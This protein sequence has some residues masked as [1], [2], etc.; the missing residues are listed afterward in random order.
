MHCSITFCSTDMGG[1]ASVNPGGIVRRQYRKLRLGTVALRVI[2]FLNA[3]APINL[4]EIK[5]VK[6]DEERQKI[7]K[8]VLDHQVPFPV[9]AESDNFTAAL[10]MEMMRRTVSDGRYG[11]R[12]AWVPRRDMISPSSLRL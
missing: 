5:G 1:R 10:V 11:V 4:T 9:G 2:N 6:V 3:A 8:K 12:L 7:M